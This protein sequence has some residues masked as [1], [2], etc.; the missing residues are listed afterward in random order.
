MCWY[1]PEI[2]T[3]GCQINIFLQCLVAQRNQHIPEE[4]R[5]F[6]ALEPRMM[7]V[8]CMSCLLKGVEQ[9]PPRGCIYG[10]E[11]YTCGCRNHTF[12]KCPAA[13]RKDH[14]PAE[15]SHLFTLDRRIMSVEC[16]SCVLE[17][18]SDKSTQ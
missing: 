17:D 12:R 5:H 3:C 16:M 15:C 13:E 6:F 11:I 9:T 2:F 1:K 14:K 18:F 7:D 8:E 10:Q 4:C